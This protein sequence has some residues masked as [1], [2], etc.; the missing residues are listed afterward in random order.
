VDGVV[1]GVW[2]YENGRIELEPF[3]RLSRPVR[4][5][6]DDEGERLAQLYA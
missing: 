1:A 2:H 3:A 5:E 4:S 6:L